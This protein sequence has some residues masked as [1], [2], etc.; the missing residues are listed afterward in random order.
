MAFP[1]SATNGQQATLNGIIYQ[2]DLANT[3]W[4][5]VTSAITTSTLTSA[6]NAANAAFTQANAAFTQANTDYTTISATA[7]TYGGSSNIPVIVLAAN[8]RVSSIVNTAISI[9]AGTSVYGNTGQITANSA[10]GTVALGLATTAVTPGSYT[11]TSLTVDAYGR[12]TAAANGAGG[13]GGVSI[14]NDVATNSNAYYP[15]LSTATTGSLST[16]NT[17]STKLYFNPS[18]GTFNSTIFNSL[19][20]KNFKTDLEQ[21]TDALNKLKTL[22][23]YTYSMIES[24]ERSAGLLSQDVSQVLPEAVKESNGIQS[25]NYNATIGLIVESIKILSDKIDLINQKLG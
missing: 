6:Y 15:M 5:R 16:A 10:T 22:T 8:G 7:G 9:P 20:D 13:G 12:I 18:T 14:T 23:G 4:L 25:L 1:T 24:G 11:S 19:S 2:Y 3:A 17:S 21:I